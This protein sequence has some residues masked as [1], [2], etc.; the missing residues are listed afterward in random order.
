MPKQ[1]KNDRSEKKGRDQK[2]GH[3]SRREETVSRKETTKREKAPA[4]PQ[5]PRTTR[6]ESVDPRVFGAMCELPEELKRLAREQSGKDLWDRLR[7]ILD[8]QLT[9]KGHKITFTKSVVQGLFQLVAWRRPALKERGD[10]A[11]MDSML[12]R[13]QAVFEWARPEDASNVVLSELVEALA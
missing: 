3:D 9:V 1:Q 12:S 5:P 13:L 7:A 11:A 10:R 8:Q 6:F 2:K 4:P